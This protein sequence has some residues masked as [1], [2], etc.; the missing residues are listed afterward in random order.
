MGT[1]VNLNRYRR[2][3]QR[4][5]RARRANERRA[6]FGMPK[7]ERSKNAA[8]RKLEASRLDGLQCEE[9]GADAKD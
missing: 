3:K 5:E 1:I 9:R 2:D 7:S 8:L 4:A 6:M